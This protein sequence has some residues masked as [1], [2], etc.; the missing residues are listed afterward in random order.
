M[1]III[2]QPDALYLS[3]AQYE[4]R[5]AVRASTH[6]ATDI[7]KLAGVSYGTLQYCTRGVHN[8]SNKMADAILSAV[9]ELDK[10]PVTRIVKPV[11]KTR[12]KSIPKKEYKS[13]TGSSIYLTPR[14]YEIRTAILDSPYSIASIADRAGISAVTIRYWITGR[15]E[16]RPALIGW[17][18]GAIEIMGRDRIS[19]RVEL[20]K[21]KSNETLQSI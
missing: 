14:Q 13:S 19:H 9:S 5:Q 4:I 7:A 20:I 6:H 16:P 10:N 8:P 15:N 21:I 17:V 11:P 3:E 18:L 1:K 12:R 2:K